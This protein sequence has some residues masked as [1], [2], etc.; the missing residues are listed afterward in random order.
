MRFPSRPAPTHLGLP[1]SPPQPPPPGLGGVNSA[2][3]GGAGE[4]W[5]TVF[6]ARAS[7]ATLPSL[8]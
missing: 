1:D 4:A 2:P 6:D 8:L 3:L 7:R 5:G